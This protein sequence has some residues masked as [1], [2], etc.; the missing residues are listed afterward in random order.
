MS[1]LARLR[2][3]CHFAR[4]EESESQPFILYALSD[5]FCRSFSV[6]DIYDPA[7]TP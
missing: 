1:R 4:S 5:P 2:G 7:I 6:D 3:S